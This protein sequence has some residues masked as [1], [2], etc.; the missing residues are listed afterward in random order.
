M[1]PSHESPAYPP[2]YT[3]AAGCKCTRESSPQCGVDGIT[4]ANPCLASCA[5]ATIAYSGS[6]E[7][8]PAGACAVVRVVLA[9]TDA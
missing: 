1:T 6:C 9:W 8:G 4:Y 2:T 3:Y 7:A 5:N